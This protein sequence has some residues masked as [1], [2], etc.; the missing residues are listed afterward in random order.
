MCTV[1]QFWNDR[2]R[3]CIDAGLLKEADPMHVSIPLWAH[4]HG[5]V[6]S[7]L[8]GMARATEEE[9]RTMYR[10]SSL[11]AISGMATE[12]YLKEAMKVMNAERET[13]GVGQ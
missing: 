9:F 2:I 3:E 10:E 4:A 1:G 13:A 5:L 12:R 7:Y 6:S 11:R 8:R